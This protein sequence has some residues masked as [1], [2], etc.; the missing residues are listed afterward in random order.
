MADFCT[1]DLILK[2]GNIVTM[3]ANDDTAEAVAVKNGLIFAVG[4][5]EDIM[6]L[7]GRGSDII[8]LEGKTVTPGLVENHCHASIVGLNMCFEVDVRQ[9]RSIDEITAL[10]ENKARE[11]RRADG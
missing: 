2:N 11:L 6:S 5:T 10:I 1:A 9:A 8:D 4:S 7:A 3:N